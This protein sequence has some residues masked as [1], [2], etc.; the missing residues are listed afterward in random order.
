MLTFKLIQE[1]YEI[2]EQSPYSEAVNN[3]LVD[4][5]LE[6]CTEHRMVSGEPYYRFDVGY[7]K[8]R[9]NGK[10]IFVDKVRNV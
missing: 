2:T 1:L 8:S 3:M 9:G 4:L 6:A 5:L 7:V 10:F